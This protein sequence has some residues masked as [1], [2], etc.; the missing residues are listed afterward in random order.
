[1]AAWI[2]IELT[3]FIHET[4]QWFDPQN[5]VQVYPL[6]SVCDVREHIEVVSVVPG[7]PAETENTEKR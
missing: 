2:S 1:M 3:E 5:Y 6:V 7:H 4:S